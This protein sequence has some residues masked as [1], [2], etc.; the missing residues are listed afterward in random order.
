MNIEKISFRGDVFL[1]K[2]ITLV[3]AVAITAVFTACSKKTG[4][5]PH[6][7][8]DTGSA[9]FTHIHGLGYSSDGKRLFIPAHNGIKVYADGK[10]SDAPGEKHDY[11]GFSMT[12]NGFYSSGHPAVGSSYKN[13]MGLIKST[14]EG[15]AITVL[16]LEGEVDLHGMSVSYRTHTLYVINP[17][18][19]SKM[20]AAGLFYSRDEGNTWISSSMSGISGQIT[21]L[22]VHPTQD[23]I[24]AI[25]TT[26][27]AYLSN[28][29]GQTFAALYTDQPVSALA[30]TDQGELLIGTGKSELVSINLQT[31]QPT[32]I[33]TPVQ[34]GDGISYLTGSPANPKELALATEKKDVYVSTDYGTDWNKIANQG[35]AIN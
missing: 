28:D 4:D 12:D 3:M 15:K 24:V 2:I 34:N 17:E 10:W 16:A 25:G 18:P 9:A 27:G 23:A 32:A 1:K 33:K 6:G 19:N 14:D 21:A 7:S 26:S 35:Q 30:F 13:P 31:K 5:D 29:N 20:K 22:A 11:M 8:H